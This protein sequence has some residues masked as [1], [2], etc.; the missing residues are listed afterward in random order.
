[1]KKLFIVAIMAI[2]AIG[3]NAQSKVKAGT[4]SIQPKAGATI[5]SITGLDDMN[6]VSSYIGTKKESQINVGATIGG[7]VE[8]QVDDR[9]SVAAGVGYILQG[10]QWDDFNVGPVEVQDFKLELGYVNVPIV[11]NFYL[12]KG[13]AV[14]AGAQFGFLTNAKVK[15]TE[16]NGDHESKESL[17]VKD[18]L[19]TFDFSIPVGVSYEFDN[20]IVIDARYNIGITNINKGGDVTN[21]NSVFLATVGYKFRL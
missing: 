1:M 13:F 21:R 19:S 7:E 20:H 6:T 16:K 12:F 8:Y 14:K 15:A 2:A 17:D 9:F 4:W 3:A 5:T 18:Q 10:K 11:A